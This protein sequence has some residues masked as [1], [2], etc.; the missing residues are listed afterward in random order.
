MQRTWAEDV[1]AWDNA[2]PA[3]LTCPSCCR[4][5]NRDAHEV[6]RS[7]N[8]ASV[9]L[10][11]TDPPYGITRNKWD[12]KEFQYTLKQTWKEWLRIVRPNGALVVMAAAPFDKILAMSCL[13]LFR[14]EW[15][16]NKNK[17][18]G[19]L[20]SRKMPL[21]AH[22]NILVFYQKPPVYNPQETLGHAPSNAVGPSKTDKSRQL[23]NYGHHD[24]LG[25]PGNRITR[26]PRTILNIPVHNNDDCAK[27]HPTQK[28][29]KLMEFFIRTYTNAGAC[30]FHPYMGS[31]TTG[32]AALKCGRRFIGAEI[33]AE[34][35]DKAK[36]RMQ[37]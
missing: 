25:N 2:E 34:Y 12:T 30:V 7:L 26:Q 9:D 8:D 5:Y 10:L 19:H 27:W 29:V 33:N 18:T 22:E 11:L 16:W 31:G 15:I 3:P 14:Y 21:K 13:D 23:R 37:L 1:F 36:S 17:A 4:L 20:N 24:C 28:P 35:F 32:V 6:C